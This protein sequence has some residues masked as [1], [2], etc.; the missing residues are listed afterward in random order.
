[1]PQIPLLEPQVLNEVVRLLQTPEN[2]VLSNLL[3]RV[4]TPVSFYVWDII[5]GSRTVAKPNVP[6]AEAHIVPRLGRAQRSASLVYLREKKEFDPTTTMWIRE[7]GSISNVQRAEEAIM[8]ELHDLNT[9]VD[10]FVEF[11]CWKALQGSLQFTGSG[12]GQGPDVLSP[13]VDY[14]FRS[15][16]TVHPATGWNTA[17]PVSIVQD[18][19]AWKR[20]AMRDARVPLT[21]AWCTSVVIDRIFN[22]FATNA[23][24]GGMLLT[25]AMRTA[26]YQNGVLPGFMGLNWHV[27]EGQYDDDSGNTQLFLQDDALVLSNLA[28]GEAMKIIEGPSADFAAPQGHIGKFSK[29]WEQEDPSGRQGLLEYR[30]LPVIT[31][32][33][34][35]VVVPDVKSTT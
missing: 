29:T 2:L 21:D 19:E 3:P 28:A 6:N 32:P 34:Q 9:R 8:R 30:F 26:F 13:T 5:K 33:D 35:I 27:I 7:L 15:S 18:V 12:T 4:A 20:L 16:H 25:D 23:A 22:A 11:A 10:N 14:G 17:S 31:R 1:M 24:S